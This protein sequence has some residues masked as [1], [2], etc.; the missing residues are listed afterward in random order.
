VVIR[1]KS[2]SLGYGSRTV[3]EDLNFQVKR[4]EFVGILGPNGSGKSTLV[5]AL[6]GLL[7]PGGGAIE[8]NGQD[9]QSLASRMRAQT[10]AVVPQSN[11][12]RFP[13]SCL[14]VV[15]MGRYPRRRRLGTLTPEDL[16][17]SLR[18]MRQ[19]TTEHLQERM[20]TEVSG[21][22]RQR[23]V[24][25]RALAQEPE[26]LMLDEA[27]ASLDVRKKLEIF[28]LCRELNREKGLTVLC[29]IHDLNLA[30]MYCR[31]LIILKDGRMVE[32][33]PTEGVFTSDILSGVYETPMEVARHPVTN[34]L[35][36][37]ML[38]L[39]EGA[40]EEPEILKAVRS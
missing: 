10:T 20:V 2:L 8:L 24:I 21:G 34:R 22:E 7:A 16:V 40:A 5:N 18:S 14:E 13:F 27:T 19:T 30:A 4:G 12:I 9:L 25:A 38:P 33:G 17:A 31:R 11:D 3:L 32:D 37:V 29:A 39:S 28:E 1:V 23:V 6:A 26:L 35:Y 15:L 36:A